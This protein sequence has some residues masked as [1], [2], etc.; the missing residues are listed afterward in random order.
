MVANQSEMAEADFEKHLHTL[1]RE[2][3]RLCYLNRP[4]I[5]DWYYDDYLYTNVRFLALMVG[6]CEKAKWMFPKYVSSISMGPV[7]QSRHFFK[8]RYHN[9]FYVL[10]DN[11]EIPFEN[12]MGARVEELLRDDNES[13]SVMERIRAICKITGVSL[14]PRF[15]SLTRE[16]RNSNGLSILEL[17]D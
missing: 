2:M 14:S 4:V 6:E 7:I 17:R 5:F 12:G 9:G 15:V 10:F 13:E 1:S 11:D 16:A 8:I 3:L